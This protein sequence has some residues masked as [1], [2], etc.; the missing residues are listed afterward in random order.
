MRS[1]VGSHNV[2]VVVVVVVNVP[3]AF[4]L[5][6]DIPRSSIPV[7]WQWSGVEWGTN[8][9]EK[10]RSVRF[11]KGFHQISASYKIFTS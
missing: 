9:A 2:V 7:A 1:L 11:S 8:E 5:D 3:D 10:W 6:L 4:G